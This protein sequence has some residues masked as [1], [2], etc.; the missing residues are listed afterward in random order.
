MAVY[1]VT[2]Y[3]VTC[4]VYASTVAQTGQVI[5]YMIQEKYTAVLSGRVA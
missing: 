5:S 2:L 4:P 1:F 3:K